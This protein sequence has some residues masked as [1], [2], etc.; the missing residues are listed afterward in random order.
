MNRIRVV[1]RAQPRPFPGTRFFCVQKKA[2]AHEARRDLKERAHSP[3]KQSARQ[4]RP[5]SKGQA[6]F[7]Q[8]TAAEWPP[9]RT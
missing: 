4:Y 9:L 6:A 1:T 7:A 3:G 5:R 2:N 8:G